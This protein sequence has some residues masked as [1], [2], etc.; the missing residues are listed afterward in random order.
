M[1][2]RRLVSATVLTFA[3]SFSTLAGDTWVPGL[4]N[5]PVGPVASGASQTDSPASYIAETAEL[6][7]RMLS[8][9]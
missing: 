3:L 2:I 5:I 1:K 9:L 4:A 6:V 8:I 7:Y